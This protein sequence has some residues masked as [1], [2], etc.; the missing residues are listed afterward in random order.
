[1][2]E[3]YVGVQVFKSLPVSRLCVVSFF[4]SFCGH[5]CK[6]SSAKTAS[7][8]CQKKWSNKHI[9]MWSAQQ[10]FSDC[11]CTTI[12]QYPWCK[13]S[14]CLYRCVPQITHQKNSTKKN[15]KPKKSAR[16]GGSHPIGGSCWEYVS[17]TYKPSKGK[18]IFQKTQVFLDEKGKY[19]NIG[20]LCR[21]W[22]YDGKLLRCLQGRVVW[23]FML[24]PQESKKR[25]HFDSCV[26]FI[27]RIGATCICYT[28]F[29]CCICT[30]YIIICIK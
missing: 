13:K 26:A 12:H 1:M 28:Y 15:A 7:V 19:W 30:V 10:S 23:S 29:V 27:D 9:L 11:S 21:G 16:R 17:V 6:N 8:K 25:G 22:S 18:V 14:M 20:S 3:G 24:Y 5:L 2:V 4:L